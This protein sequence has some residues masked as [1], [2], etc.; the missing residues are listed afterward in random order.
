MKSNFIFLILISLSLLLSC[1]DDDSKLGGYKEV[2]DIITV[3]ELRVA[4]QGVDLPL[5]RQTLHKMERT[6]GVVVMSPKAGNNINSDEIIIQ[7]NDVKAINNTD[8]SI[9]IVLSV[10]TNVA[11]TMELGDSLVVSLTGSTLVEKDGRLKVLNVPTENIRKAMTGRTVRPRV[12]TLK[13][14]YDN[15]DKYEDML[16]SISADINPIPP[17]GEPLAGFK[18]MPAG[19]EGSNIY[20]YTRSEASFASKSTMPSA[21]VVGVVGL[22]ESKR[23]VSMRMVEDMQNESGPLYPN[24]P[25]DF[26]LPEI[27]GGGV[28]SDL[29][30]YNSGTNKGIFKT[31]EWLLYQ[32]ILVDPVDA[33]TIGRDK[34][35]GAQGI[36]MQRN[37]KLLNNGEYDAGNL[38]MTSDLK[39][40]AT[41]ITFTYG[42]Y[43][44]DAPITFYAQISQ[45]SG[46]TWTNLGNPIEATHDMQTMVYMVNYEG[47]IRFRI[48]KPGVVTENGR[49]SIDNIYIHQKTW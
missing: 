20:L 11:S 41:K 27:K 2:S 46:A 10:G 7:A 29:T 42:I 1:S 4:Y 36:R 15:F 39:N 23:T 8:R 12:A 45:D 48:H 21:D 32:S 26:E 37:L 31:G 6:T 28:P 35:T 22:V 16:V 30:S 34:I 25:E 44:T 3:D 49:L 40:G 19:E 33:G 47:T 24:W 5:N 38:E 18:P 14:I 13:E 17:S 9:G 43:Y